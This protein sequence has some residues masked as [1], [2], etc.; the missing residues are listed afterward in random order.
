MSRAAACFVAVVLTFL[1]GLSHLAS[2]QVTTLPGQPTPGPAQPPPRDSALKPATAVIRGRVVAAD[3]GQPL[4]RAQ[5]RVFAA[6]LRENRMTSTD[7]DGKYELKDLPAGRYTISV[8]KGSYVS[9]SYGQQRP[10]E[11]GKPL[12]VR[13]GQVVEKVDFALPKG[14]VITGRVLDEFGEPVSG[15]QVA[16]MRYNTIQGSRRLMPAGGGSSTNDIGEF[17]VFGLSPGQY[18]LSATLRNFNFMGADSDDRSG[19][20]PSYYPGTA[21]V[22]EAQRITVGV[23]QILTDLNMVLIPTRTARVSGTVVSSSGRPASQGVVMAM[24]REGFMGPSAVGQ[25]RPD[26]T[27]QINSVPP[28]QYTLQANLPPPSGAGGSQEFATAAVTVAGEDISGVQLVGARE[29][30]L[31]GR[32][33]IDPAT[34]SGLQ[35][36][37]IR[38]TAQPLRPEFGMPGPGGGGT[39]KDDLTFEFRARP[40]P[41]VIRAN[42]GPPNGSS[43]L[44]LKA[45]RLNGADITDT[46]LDIRSNEDVTGL[47]VEL[48]SRVTEVSGTVTGEHGDA[49]KDYWVVIF[50]QDHERWTQ[51]SR[52]F[53][54]ARPDQDG[55]FKARSLPPGQYYAIAVDQLEQGQ[56]ADPEFLDRVRPRATSFTLE[57]GESKTIDLKLTTG[58]Q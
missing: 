5:V 10:F 15:V 14:A 22:A 52:F 44:M 49:A 50:A 18:Y 47:E 53:A 41:I 33:V 36:S 16:P 7:P 8:S 31:S 1:S 32:I 48:T 6:E 35:A 12:D 9:L 43:A 29:S 51:P 58:I 11:A 45:V 4:R 3:S 54:S 21:N 27:F 57:E 55:R 24:A 30:A 42:S 19:Y 28:G 39:V 25:I 26:G 34:A 37:T 56:G 23:G 2:A 38:V 20:A 17:R 46:G 13:D 40:G